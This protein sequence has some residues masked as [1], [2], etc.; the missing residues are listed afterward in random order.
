MKV[1]HGNETH[2]RSRTETIS[3]AT[4]RAIAECRDVS[5]SVREFVGRRDTTD[6]NPALGAEVLAVQ[7]PYRG[8]Y[9]QSRER[10]LENL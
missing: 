9:V 7:T 8:I 3:Y 2:R 4:P 6:F 10:K 1:K 5:P